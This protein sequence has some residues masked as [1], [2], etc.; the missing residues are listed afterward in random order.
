MTDKKPEQGNPIGAN[1]EYVGADSV[2]AVESESVERTEE[3][4]KTRRRSTTG[5]RVTRKKKS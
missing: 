2:Q 1:G 3:P 5:R 4:K